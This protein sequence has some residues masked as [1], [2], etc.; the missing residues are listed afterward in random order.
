MSSE[1]W[2][3]PRVEQQGI[4]GFSEMEKNDMRSSQKGVLVIGSD[5]D[6]YQIV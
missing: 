4:I 3:G 2:W 5:Q 6:N 1:P